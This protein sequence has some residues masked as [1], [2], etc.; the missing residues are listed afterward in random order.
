MIWKITFMAIFSVWFLLRLYFA[1]GTKGQTSKNACYPQSEK[2]MV[3][4][5]AITMMALPLMIVFTSWLDRFS[6][7]LPSWLRVSAAIV[8]AGSVCLFAWTHYSLGKFWSPILEIRDK[9]QLIRT[10]PY[11]WVRHPMYSQI[12]IWVLLQGVLLDNWLLGVSGTAA[13]MLL[14]CV[15]IPREER[16]MLDEF[17]DEYR[18][19]IKQTN[20]IIP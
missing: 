17:G 5:N 15:R 7:G 19:F 3:F 6:M 18:K 2:F 10:G 9:H 1:K 8:M 20:R 4:L 11:A 16:M 14:Y 12:W 13:W